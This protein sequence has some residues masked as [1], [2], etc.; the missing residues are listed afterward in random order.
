M[1]EDTTLPDLAPDTGSGDPEQGARDYETVRRTL[2]AITERWRDQPAL[3]DLAREAGVQPIQLQRV[4]SRWAGITP[5]QFLQAIT[6]D[7]ARDLL[8]RSATVLDTTY[9][10]GLSGPARLH[11]LFVTHEAMTPG[12]YRAGGEGVTISWGF[13][14]SPFGKALVMATPHGLAGLAF[15]DPGEERTALDDMMGRWPRASYVED[16][17][18]TAPIAGR[19]FD[20]ARWSEETPLR[21]VLIGTDFEIR[22]WETLLRIPLGAA[23]TYATIADRLGKPKAARAVGRAVGRNPISFVVPCHRVLGSNGKLCG[24]HWGLTRKRAILGWEAGLSE[25][26]LSAVKRG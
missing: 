16:R 7:H 5:K 13:H 1:L 23:T 19:I 22:V 17:E 8:R 10:L 2:R 20:P 6:L 21:V 11:D 4:F 24:Y 18:S 3:E 25:P 26:V 12:V 14:P 9:E 15:A